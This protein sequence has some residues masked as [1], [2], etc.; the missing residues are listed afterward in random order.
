M[1]RY[2]KTL[3]EKVEKKELDPRVVI[4]HKLP[5]EEV[6]KAYKIFNDKEDG[7]VKVVLHTKFYQG[8]YPESEQGAK[9][10]GAAGAGGPH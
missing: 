6:A 10:E 1:Q 7:C 2:C 4:T 9:D 8:Q 5:L 3:L